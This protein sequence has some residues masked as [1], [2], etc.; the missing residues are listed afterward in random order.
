MSQ[1]NTHICLESPKYIL[2]CYEKALQVLKLQYWKLVLPRGASWQ[3]QKGTQESKCAITKAFSQSRELSVTSSELRVQ[4]F[5]KPLYYVLYLT[6]YKYLINS[7]F[8]SS[9]SWFVFDATWGMGTGGMGTGGICSFHR[10]PLHDQ[11]TSGYLPQ[12]PLGHALCSHIPP[13]HSYRQ[14]PLPG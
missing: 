7:C 9:F 8:R 1:Y 3:E 5:K 11:G 12:P 4:H 2:K 13:L 14:L 6:R 10:Q